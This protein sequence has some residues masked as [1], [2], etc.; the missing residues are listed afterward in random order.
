MT[1]V[2]QAR[3]GKGGTKG[4]QNMAGWQGNAVKLGN[5]GRAWQGR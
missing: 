5:V 3:Q 4:K 2:R 1:V